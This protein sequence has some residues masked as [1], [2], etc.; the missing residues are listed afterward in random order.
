[1][2]SCN[3]A[4]VSDIPYLNQQRFFRVRTQR[5]TGLKDD[6]RGRVILL[7]CKASETL[8]TRATSMRNTNIDSMEVHACSPLFHGVHVRAKSW[9]NFC[10]IFSEEGATSQLRLPKPSLDYPEHWP[11]RD[12]RKSRHA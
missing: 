10:L 12:Y 6:V 2:L 4:D 3:I 11:T 7:A 5:Q 1:M 9:P 8:L